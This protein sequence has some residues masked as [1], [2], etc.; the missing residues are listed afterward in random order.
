MD[1]VIKEFN[2]EN[3][4]Y[5]LGYNLLDNKICPRIEIYKNGN[6]LSGGGWY[7]SAIVESFNFGTF[8]SSDAVSGIGTIKELFAELRKYNEISQNIEQEFENIFLL[9]KMNNFKKGREN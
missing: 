8:S 6:L 1:K 3:L 2:H 7:Y 5:E 9:Y 4:I